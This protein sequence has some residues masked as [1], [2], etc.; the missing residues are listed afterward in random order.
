MNSAPGI[1]I[2]P[3]NKPTKE[4]LHKPLRDMDLQHI[5]PETGGPDKSIPLTE[6]GK[7][8]SLARQSQVTRDLLRRHFVLQAARMT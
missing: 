7:R 6:F 2:S 3:I 1:K 5:L 8:F 4:E